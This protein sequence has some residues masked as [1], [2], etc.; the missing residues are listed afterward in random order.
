MTDRDAMGRFAQG[1]PGGPGRPPRQTEVEYL[2]AIQGAC[3]P[4]DLSQ[5]AVEAVRRAREGDPRARDWIS[6]YLVGTALAAAPKPSEA[7]WQEESGFDPV[8]ARVADTRLT[9]QLLAGL[10]DEDCW[11]AGFHSEAGVS[12]PRLRTRRMRSILLSQC[13]SGPALRVL[14]ARRLRHH[15]VEHREQIT[16]TPRSSSHPRRELDS[17]RLTELLRMR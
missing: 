10:F 17:D 7:I 11:R 6:R 5:I 13:G 1:N 3:S 16:S 9:T 2:R 12:G 8:E 4:D 14:S 15:S